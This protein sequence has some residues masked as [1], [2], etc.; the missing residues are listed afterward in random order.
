MGG[1]VR[2]FIGANPAVRRTAR[3]PR[4]SSRG[5]VA[6]VGQRQHLPTA[7]GRLR[8]VSGRQL[9]PPEPQHLYRAAI[10]PWLATTRLCAYLRMRCKR[11]CGLPRGGDAALPKPW[12][13]RLAKHETHSGSE[14]LRLACRRG[15]HSSSL[16]RARFASAIAVSLAFPCLVSAPHDSGQ[17]CSGSFQA[18]E[19]R[20]AR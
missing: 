6:I 9:H 13:G 1:S 10:R 12:P 20:D 18:V 2:P 3:C 17:L 7:P 8:Q 11:R 5:A 14:S 19:R 15:G 16:F 4:G